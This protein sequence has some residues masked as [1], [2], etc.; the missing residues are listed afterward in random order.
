MITRQHL[1]EL[2]VVFDQVWTRPDDTHI[3][4]QDIQKLRD[5]INTVAA[6]KTSGRE[7]S[8]IAGDGLPCWFSTT[9]VHGPK[10][11]DLESAILNPGAGLAVEE[12]AR[13]LERLNNLDQQGS[14]RKGDEC[15]GDGNYQVEQP[16]NNAME[17]V[18]AVRGGT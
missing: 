17:G 1:G 6:K 9:A 11:K 7:Y 3:S 10:L 16:L 14:Q 13:G 18:L 8:G 15:R 5:F 2:V 4:V 12:G